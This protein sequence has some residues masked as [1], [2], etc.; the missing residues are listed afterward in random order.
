MEKLKGRFLIIDSG[1]PFIKGV[2]EPYCNVIYASAD[3]FP[4][5]I[6][7]VKRHIPNAH[8]ALIIRTRTRCNAELLRG[9]GV[10]I[11][12]TATIGTDHIDLDYCAA[13]SIKVESAAGCNS[14]GVMQYVYTALALAE[15]RSKSSI[16]VFSK[17]PE[18][19]TIGVVGAGNVGGK[20][21]ALAQ[22]LG[23][24]V[25]VNDPPKQHLH[26]EY[27][28]LDELLAV[29]DIVTLHVPLDSS[30]R[31]LADAEFF[32]KMKD[33]ALFINTSRGEVANE[34]A[35]LAAL[36]N[37][38]QRKLSGCILDVWRSEPNIN[39]TLLENALVVTPHIAG[40]SK[41]GKENGTQ[42]VVRAAAEF[43]GIEPLRDF[44]VNPSPSY[45]CLDLKK[46]VAPQLLS[47]F[48]IEDIDKK[49]RSAPKEFETLRNS[50]ALRS[51][52]KTLI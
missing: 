43:L 10:D 31:D 49:L 39:K 38:S 12:A 4:A 17:K 34:D 2:F 29:S 16:R 6:W 45:N 32:S 23:W 11:I 35:L 28:S 40:Y 33:G 9:S 48:D 14:G 20:V 46:P 36:G 13:N 1:I 44:T 25:L 30:T 42:M 50:F 5:E 47:F 41:E 15:K 24:K 8:I 51:E 52:F 18:D 37:A 27:I 21:L 7:W 19:L 22:K 26:P 3:A